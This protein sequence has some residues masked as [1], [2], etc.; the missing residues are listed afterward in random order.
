MTN[1]K[2]FTLIVTVSMALIAGCGPA[3][4]MQDLDYGISDHMELPT[5]DLAY[6]PYDQMPYIAWDDFV[7]FPWDEFAYIP[8]HELPYLPWENLNYQPWDLYPYFPW[9]DLPYWPWDEVP[10][11]PGDDVPYL[12]EIPEWVKTLTPPWKFIDIG[13][14]NKQTVA[15]TIQTDLVNNPDVLMDDCNA[16]YSCVPVNGK[17]G[18]Y[19]CSANK[20]GYSS[21]NCP[22]RLCVKKPEAWSCQ[23]IDPGTSIDCPTEI[24]QNVTPLP[25]NPKCTQYTSSD[26]CKM[27]GCTWIDL[28]SGYGGYCQ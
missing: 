8:W 22:L 12:Y 19:Y 28:G 25:V 17:P 5:G 13:C 15:I 11:L 4:Q 7:Y 3:K 14:P 21:N 23:D 27:N 9:D 16:K 20:P 18:W 1:A 26:I 6:L 24:Q 10:Y 2:R